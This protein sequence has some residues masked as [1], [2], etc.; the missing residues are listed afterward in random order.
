MKARILI[1]AVLL[2]VCHL[3]IFSQGAVMRV[4]TYN[5]P[6]NGIDEVTG[7][8]M[9]YD[10]SVYVTGY[11]KG[12]SS[13][14]DFA[15]IKFNNTGDFL[16]V[17][18]FNGTGNYTDRAT[19]ITVDNYGNVYVTGWAHMEPNDYQGDEIMCGTIDYVTIKY[20]PYGNQVWMKVYA[21]PG[22]GDDIPSAIL[23]DRFG[24]VY[25]TGTSNSGANKEDYLTIKYNNNGVQQWVA[26][27][28]GVSHDADFA[29]AFALDG[30]GGVY[31][32]GRSY[33]S[34]QM[35]DY[36]T[37]KY[38]NEGIQ[39]WTSRYNGPGNGDDIAYSI[40]VDVNDNSYVTGASKGSSSNLDYATVKIGSNG[41]QIWAKRYNGPGNNIDEAHSLIL[42]PYGTCYV[43]GFS[44]G[45]GS[46]Y[47]Y[48]TLKYD[49]NGNEVWSQRYN[50]TGNGIDKAWKIGLVKRPCGI[51]GDYPCWNF[52]LYVTGQSVGS[53][54]GDDFL[55]IKYDQNGNLK[56]SCRYASS[57]NISDVSTVSA[58]RDDFGY[59]YTAGRINNDYGI[60]QISNRSTITDDPLSVKSPLELPK[61]YRLGQN[62]PN[63]FNPSTVINYE[64]PNSG[65]V[66]LDVYDLLGKQVASLVKSYMEPGKYNVSFDASNL[67]SGTYIYTIKAGN[68]VESKKMVLMK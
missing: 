11:S 54:T 4:L 48:A 46:N 25:V 8:M 23:L 41:S 37:V 9:N 43:T 61:D 56:W 14:E 18:R 52:D 33:K 45:S 66:E 30:D 36:V 65:L 16:W 53:G 10:G 55:T 58:L 34:G 47:D 60:V 32:T 49:P 31:V 27:Y 19:A 68:Y 15:T 26:R 3:S 6:G 42:D 1:T 67:P 35:A 28:D 2:F 59:F 17:S 39:E 24:N 51:I 12:S 40:A 38:N 44:M 5:G 62:Y 64:V 57:G 20:D 13:D 21:G 7:M 22:G 29:N 63:P 50:G